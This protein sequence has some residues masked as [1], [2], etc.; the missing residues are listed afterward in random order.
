MGLQL[1]SCG[2]AEVHDPK[3]SLGKSRG[4]FDCRLSPEGRCE[5]SPTF[6]RP[7]QGWVVVSRLHKPRKGRTNP[8]TNTRSC[9]CG[10]FESVSIRGKS[11]SSAASPRLSTFE[12]GSRFWRLFVLL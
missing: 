3:G 9:I 10:D 2:P 11:S 5:N 8:A 12:S 1:Q 4:G 7:F 6:S